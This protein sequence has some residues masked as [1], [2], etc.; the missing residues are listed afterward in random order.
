MTPEAEVKIMADLQEMADAILMVRSI[1]HNDLYASR[2][3]HA[4]AALEESL[5]T[6]LNWMTTP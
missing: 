3:K 4:T 6:A 1:L 5:E 2:V